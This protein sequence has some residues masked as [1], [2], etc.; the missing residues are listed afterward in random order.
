MATPCDCSSR[1]PDATDCFCMFIV[2][3]G[4]CGCEC[5]SEPIVLP[6]LPLKADE[7]VNFNAKNAEL[8]KVAEFLDRASET[9]VLI[10]ASKLRGRVSVS[11]EGVSLSDAM[12]ELGLVAGPEPAAP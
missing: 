3:T 8:G 4:E 6:P 1:C 9:N 2:S 11:L 5:S 10:P 7:E 12:E